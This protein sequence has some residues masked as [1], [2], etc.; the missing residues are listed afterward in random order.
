MMSHDSDLIYFLDPAQAIDGI[1]ALGGPL[2]T[3]NLL[4]AYCSGIFP[5]P[6]NEDILPWCCPAKRGILD[7]SDLHIPRRLA[8]TR[9]Q[10][11]FHFTI[12][13]SFPQVITHCAT[14]Q[15]KGESV[16]WITRQMMRAYCELYR[17]GHAHSVEVWEGTELVGGL[18]G[19]DACGSFSGESMFSFRSNASKLALLFLIGHL[20]ERGLDW[21]D[22][23]MVTPHLEALG[24]KVVSRADFLERLTATQTCKLILFPQ[25]G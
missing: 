10:S 8:R 17:Q 23:Q 18:Y 19:V 20:K 2:T 13:R 22:I 9:H 1:V 14:V 11:T 5:W 7:F 25:T 16:T 15:R 6:I 12:D 4:R 3:T 21:I 24:A